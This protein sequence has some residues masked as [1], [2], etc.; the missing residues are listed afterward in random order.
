MGE[1][2][3]GILLDILG[4]VLVAVAVA[5][6]TWW[7]LDGNLKR[8][9]IANE[10]KK[11]GIGAIQFTAPGRRDLQ[12]VFEK[13]DRIRI[14]FVSGKGFFLQNEANKNWLRMAKNRRATI[15][16]LLAAEDS[17]F[18]RDI[19]RLEFQVGL[20]S[21]GQTISDELRAVEAY[22]NKLE[23]DV[24]HFNTEFRAPMILADYGYDPESATYKKSEGWLYV[25]LPPYWSKDSI[26]LKSSMKKEE[27]SSS[28]DLE[29]GNLAEMMATH[30]EAVWRQA[31]TAAAARGEE[32]APSAGAAE[33]GSA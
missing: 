18:V 6:V 10:L 7:F 21:D 22:L 17:D 14:V 32:I 33:T 23:I 12:R 25:S 3:T 30:F 31:G 26:F 19:E 1:Y 16:V 20:R 2:L 13:A 29:L 24:R 9:T 27:R 4:K 28:Q 5:G 8:L 15:Q 11:H